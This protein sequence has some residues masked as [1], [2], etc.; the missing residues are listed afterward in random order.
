VRMHRSTNKRRLTA[1][2]GFTVVE[3]LVACA[4]LAVLM[5]VTLPILQKAGQQAQAAEQ[6]VLATQWVLAEL[7]AQ[8]ARP[9]EQLAPGPLKISLDPEVTERLAEAEAEFVA[10][11]IDEPAAGLRITGKLKW[12]GPHGEPVRPVELSTWVFEEAVE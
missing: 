3:I 8:T 9:I 6:R 7:D 2:H 10:E 4:M 12:I 5:A 11:R 1:G